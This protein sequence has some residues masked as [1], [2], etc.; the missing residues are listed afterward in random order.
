MSLNLNPFSTPK[1]KKKIMLM[2]TRAGGGHIST[3]RAIGE[4]LLSLYPNEVEIVYFDVASGGPKAVSLFLSQG[5]TF[6][7]EHLRWVWNIIFFFSLFEMWARLTVWFFGVQLKPSMMRKILEEKPDYIVSTY[8]L[9]KPFKKMLKAS[10]L[11]T[12]VLTVVSDPFSPST[13]WFLDRSAQYIVMSDAAK[14]FALSRRIPEENLTIFKNIIH[15]KFIKTKQ[16]I[17]KKSKNVLL[18]GGGLGLK[19]AEAII[20]QAYREGEV[21]NFT[22]ICGKNDAQ[23]RSI[24]KLIRELDIKNVTLY[25]FVDFVDQLIEQSDIVVSKAGPASLMEI[26]ALKKNLII[27][28]YIW[29]QELGN[30]KWATQSHYA[31]YEHKPYKIVYMLKEFF[32]ENHLDSLVSPEIIIETDTLAKHILKQLETIEK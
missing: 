30:L 22:V 28:D 23:Y 4:S 24:S 27:T 19:Q 10:N 2:Y 6:I 18:F 15:T 26:F 8:F 12:E 31:V 11:S 29:G 20:L 13:I 5:Y 17:H 32:D 1:K 16:V 3:A 14:N 25:G 21:F 9:T 7:V